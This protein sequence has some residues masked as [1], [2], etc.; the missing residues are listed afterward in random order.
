MS[1][2]LEMNKWY[3][4]IILLFILVLLYFIAFQGFVSEHALMNEEIAELEESRQEY[5]ELASMI[6]E[7]Q[8]R[9]NLVKETVGDST[10]FLKEDN[11]NLG[12]AEL[13][14]ILKGIV[15]SVTTVRSECNMTHQSPFKDKNQDQFEKIVLK[16]RMRCQFD[17]VID[18][19]SKIENNVPNM[20]LDNISL[21]QRTIHKRRN[22]KP[23]KPV[24][25]V[26]FDVYAY[27]NK[28]VRERRSND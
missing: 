18:V 17:K 2:N 27:M 1:K 3:A 10:H 12:S 6:P 25:D 8:R 14:Q 11:Y 13:T 7:L 15:N 28:P 26:R 23:V 5:A 16:V 22:V 24:L 4:L 19:L 20:F 9:I 21:D